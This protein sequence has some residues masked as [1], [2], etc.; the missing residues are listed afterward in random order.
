MSDHDAPVT[1]DCGWPIGSFACKIRH[2]FLNSGD[3]KA[4][5]D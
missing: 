3:C 5:N 2:V 1:C 4:A